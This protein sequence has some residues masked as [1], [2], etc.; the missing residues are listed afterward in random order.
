M[1]PAGLLMDSNYFGGPRRIQ[2][3]DL[4]RSAGALTADNQIIFTA[5]LRAHFLDRRAH[6][7]NVLFLGEIDGRLI[8]EWAF[9][10]ADLQTDRGFHSC[11][12]AP[13]S[14]VWIANPAADRGVG[15]EEL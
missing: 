7:A 3:L 14:G 8:P 10:Q 5:Q 12:D 9:V 13:L 4:L 11:H 15:K 2:G 1:V 6:A